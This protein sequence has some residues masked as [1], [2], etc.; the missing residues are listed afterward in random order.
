MKGKYIF[1]LFV[2]ILFSSATG[3]AV[4]DGLVD[5]ITGVKHPRAE[6]NSEIRRRRPKAKTYS[7]T[8]NY[9]SGPER[10]YKR[11]TRKKMSDEAMLGS[12]S[13]SLWQQQGQSGYL[14][15]ENPLKM[16]GDN[17]GIRIEGDSKEQLNEKVRAIKNL[18][19]K[20]KERREKATKRM[21]MKRRMRRRDV[22]AMEGAPL[23]PLKKDPKKKIAKKQ[24]DQKSKSGKK[25]ENYLDFE[26]VATRVVEK[27][28]DG[29]YRVKGSRPILISNREY[30]VIVDGVAKPEDFEGGEISSDKLLDAQFDI[31]STRRKGKAKWQ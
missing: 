4:F 13:G 16:I 30:R 14:F 18:M 27:L 22:A 10:K 26:K 5:R 21:A 19:V 12:N 7:A 24:V 11:M 20:L 23:P 9:M 1:R 8:E 28:P 17:V 25:D 15:S 3:C 29:N 2:L 6:R 31:V